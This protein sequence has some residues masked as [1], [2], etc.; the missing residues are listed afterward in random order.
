MVNSPIYLFWLDKILPETELQM[1]NR[2]QTGLNA[3]GTCI[4]SAKKDRSLIT[5]RTAGFFPQA[6]FA[7]NVLMTRQVRIQDSNIPLA[8]GLKTNPREKQMDSQLQQDSSW[9]VWRC[10]V[11]FKLVTTECKYDALTESCSPPLRCC[12]QEKVN[13]EKTYLLYDIAL[14]ITMTPSCFI[15]R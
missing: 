3:F 6:P 14:Y 5:L 4:G 7:A 13:L 10:F 9:S 15:V 11:L 2:M 12:F 1:G 8:S